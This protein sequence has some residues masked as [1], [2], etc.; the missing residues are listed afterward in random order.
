MRWVNAHASRG[1]RPCMMISMPRN[2]VEEAHALVIFPFSDCASMRRWPS[3]RVI[4]ST[5]TLVLAIVVLRFVPCIHL[6]AGLTAADLREHGPDRMGGDPRGGADR[7][8]RSDG[9][10]ALLDRIAADV[11]EAPVE[12]GHRVPE[13]RFG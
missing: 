1:S 6:M 10:H 4:G 9:V 7:E 5:T 13:V 3:M 12:R 8:G 11:G 2:C